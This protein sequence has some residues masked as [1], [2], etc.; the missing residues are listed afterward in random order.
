MNEKLTIPQIKPTIHF[1]G[2]ELQVKITGEDTAGAFS[3]V[4]F[5]L[6]PVTLGAPL[7]VHHNEDLFLTVLDGELVIQIDEQAAAIK[8]NQS[9]KITRSTPFAVWN[10]SNHAVRFLEILQPAGF[11]QSFFEL[12]EIFSADQAVEYKAI[13]ALEMKYGLETDFQSIFELTEQYG[14]QY[15][16]RY[17]SICW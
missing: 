14:L 3:V 16:Q 17:Q 5:R 8:S 10:Q 4:E 13:C 6:D 12:D 7:H 9:I 2:M 1:E 15:D 11:E